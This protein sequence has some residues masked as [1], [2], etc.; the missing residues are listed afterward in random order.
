M[1][2]C[3]NTFCNPHKYEP[4]TCDD[5]TPQGN[6]KPHFKEGTVRLADGKVVAR[7]P[8]DNPFHPTALRWVAPEDVRA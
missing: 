5:L 7:V 8:T 6:P 4:P 2:C 3:E 1:A